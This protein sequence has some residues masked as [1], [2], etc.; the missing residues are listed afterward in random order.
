[1]PISF[2]S[3]VALTLFT[4]AAPLVGSGPPAGSVAPEPGFRSWIQRKGATKVTLEALRGRVVLLHTF[5]WN[6]ASCRKVGIPLVV[7]LLA[8][9]EDRGLSVVSVTTPA[10]PEET[11]KVIEGFG[12]RHP[13]AMEQPLGGPN[14]YVDGMANPITYVFVVGR[15]GDVVWRG[16][17]S[18]ELEEC[19][20]A[21]ARALDQPSGRALERTLHAELA[22]PVRLYFAGEWNAA[23][24]AARKLGLKHGRRSK[25]DSPT[26]A[27]DAAYLQERITGLGDTL[28]SELEQAVAAGEAERIA[29]TRHELATLLR[30]SAWSKQ[31]EAVLERLD[32]DDTLSAAVEAAESW[33]ELA[34]ARPALFPVRTDDKTVVRY[35]KALRRFVEKE[36][37]SP[38]RER[39]E[40]RLSR[41]EEL[42]RAK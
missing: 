41:W 2:L 8:A 21:V 26:I 28:L 36:A 24:K 34:A 1:M 17:P 20:A 27:A 9:N 22:E 38:Y 6:C 42:Q 3:T 37:E 19:V 25:G 5:A 13:V 40:A 16:D 35:A 4:S 29:R 10:F 23:L 15:N 7:D 14:P 33:R 18:T 11:K 12:V 31:A 39:A 32:D 30:K